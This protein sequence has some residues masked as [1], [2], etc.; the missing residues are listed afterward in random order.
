MFDSKT[1]MGKREREAYEKSFVGRYQKLVKKNSFLYFGLP[2]MLSIALGSVLL[3]NF[4]ALRYE[5]RDEKVKE[6]NEEDALSMI[7]NRRKVDIK[8]EYYKLQG[9]LEEHEDWEPKRV[10]R[11]PG[12]DHNYHT[13]CITEAE[14]YEGALYKGKKTKKQQ[15][16]QFQ[17]KK[18]VK[19]EK[20]KEEPKKEDKKEEEEEEK[21]DLS[22]YTK[23]TTSLY[24]VFKAAKKNHKSIADKT[25]F[26]KSI[27][28]S[29][30]KDGSYNL[31]L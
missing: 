14:K 10:E 20:P 3:S 1:F 11:L 27:K 16:P 8:D 9:L 28:V 24:K 7:N 31:S 13:S 5:R 15:H 22:K 4:T 18:P 17:Y 12:N 6:M 21:I 25:E 19:N 2:M 30:N 29:L 23:H 26:L